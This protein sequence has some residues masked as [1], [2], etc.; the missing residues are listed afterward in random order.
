MSTSSLALPCISCRKNNA[1]ARQPSVRCPD[2]AGR[3]CREGG[4]GRVSRRGRRRRRPWEEVEKRLE[5]WVEKDVPG[6]WIPA[7]DVVFKRWVKPPGVEAGGSEA[8]PRRGGDRSWPSRPLKRPSSSSMAS[9]TEIRTTRS[10]KA[11]ANTRSSF[12]KALPKLAGSVPSP[13]RGQPSGSMSH[14]RRARPARAA[15]VFYYQSNTD[16]LFPKAHAQ[17]WC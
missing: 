14:R 2:G 16:L 8:Q 4:A 13:P 1:R 7:M 6:F 10:G 5:R 3:H 9:R 11:L 17:L 12:P 15:E